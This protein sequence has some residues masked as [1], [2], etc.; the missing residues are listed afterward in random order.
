MIVEFTVTG[1][2]HPFT[3]LICRVTAGRP[4]WRRRSRRSREWR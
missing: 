3:T 4:G 2:P 1:V